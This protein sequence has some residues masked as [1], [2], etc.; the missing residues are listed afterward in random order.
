MFSQ[1]SNKV[2]GGICMKYMFEK[3]MR[4]MTDIMTYCHMLGAKAY[5]IEM[6]T[7]DDVFNLDISCD[8][9][10]VTS[11]VLDELD[12]ELNRPRQMEIEQNYWGLSGDVDTDCELTLIGM[13]VDRAVITYDGTTLHIHA[14]RI[15][16]E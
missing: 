16:V 2:Y 11:L 4:I 1:W 9:E 5:N 10:N 8:A 12:T 14:E 6:K 3:Q 7:V 13:M 15:E